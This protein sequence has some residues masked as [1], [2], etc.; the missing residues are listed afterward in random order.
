LLV[1]VL[2]QVEGDL[3]RTLILVSQTDG[4]LFGAVAGIAHANGDLLTRRQV[5]E[6]QDDLRSTA[7]GAGAGG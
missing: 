1:A 4:D 7:R 2:T 5:A 6:I 3:F